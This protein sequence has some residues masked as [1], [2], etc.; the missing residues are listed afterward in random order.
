MRVRIGVAMAVVS[1]FAIPRIAS[2]QIMNTAV[3]ITAAP[4]GSNVLQNLSFGTR[5]PGQT[6]DTGPGSNGQGA[7]WEF[8][9]LAKNVSITLDF[10]A[11]LLENASTDQLSVSYGNAGYGTW[12]TRKATAACGDANTN[13]ADFNPGNISDTG[14][15]QIGSVT[16]NTNNTGTGNNDRV[17]TVWVGARLPIPASTPSGAYSGTL[18]VTVT[19]L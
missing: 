3:S 1:L 9:G 14:P 19:I 6:V 11:T 17:L 13:V 7:I 16:A 15:G 4:V 8:T 18:T 12:C 2:A 5:T 10:S